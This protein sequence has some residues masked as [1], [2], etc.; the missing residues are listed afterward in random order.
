MAE[1]AKWMF[2]ATASG[3]IVSGFGVVVALFGVMLVR[4]QLRHTATQTA[5]AVNQ[6]RIANQQ[7]M[8][9]KKPTLRIRLEHNNI[10]EALD[11]DAEFMDD[12]EI[13]SVQV[14][15]SN[16][17]AEGTAFL[18]EESLIE[19]G[20]RDQAPI[21]EESSFKRHNLHD[22]P[23]L[24]P[25]ES[26]SFAAGGAG[27]IPYLDAM[28]V[29]ARKARLF[30]V[31]LIR[32]RDENGFDWEMGYCAEWTRFDRDGGE[33]IWALDPFRAPPH[34]FDRPRYPEQ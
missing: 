2:Y 26:K 13:P 21:P 1:W 17:A 32:Y 30:F 9:S 19:I 25:G 18:I 15:L 12:A 29:L 34:I 4:D 20:A 5:A 27:P 24:A 16:I 6:A 3:L 10:P 23:D 7:F 33:P 11:Q 22:L 14:T 31:A 28:D 8:Y